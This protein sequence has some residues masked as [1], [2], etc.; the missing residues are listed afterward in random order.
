MSARV[1]SECNLT[2][3][4]GMNVSFGMKCTAWGV[5]V[6]SKTFVMRLGKSS[7]IIACMSSVLFN[8]LTEGGVYVLLTV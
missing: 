7:L 5:G 8:E 1:D 6:M 2:S 4:F 3:S